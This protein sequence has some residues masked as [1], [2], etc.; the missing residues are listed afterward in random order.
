MRSGVMNFGRSL[1]LGLLV[2]SGGAALAD[3]P[4]TVQ[5]D[6]AQ[7]MTLDQALGL[8]PRPLVVEFTG[9]CDQDVTIPGDNITLRGADASARRGTAVT[10]GL[11]LR[12]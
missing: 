7:G 4:H 6:C 5:V 11:L 9:T 8:H 10:F 12:R 2:L 3:G 1:S